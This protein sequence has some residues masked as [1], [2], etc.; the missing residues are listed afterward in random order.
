M[1]LSKE[2]I[3]A[4]VKKFGSNETDTGNSRVQIALLTTRIR[5]LTEHCKANKKDAASR[6][7]LLSLVGQR[8]RLQQ[9]YKRRDLDG[10]R[11]LIAELG[12]RK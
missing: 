3:A 8:R 7:G 12:L 10:Y 9:Y 1:A 2:E 5:Q 11:E 4:V 6:R